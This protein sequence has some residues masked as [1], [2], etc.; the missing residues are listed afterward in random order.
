ME[1]AQHILEK[2]HALT[3]QAKG[4]IADSKWDAAERVLTEAIAL[5]EQNAFAIDLLAKCYAGAGKAELA[6]RTHARAK[7]TREEAWKRQVE[8]DIRSHHELMGKKVQHEIP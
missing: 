1:T 5:D 6:E 2:V 8:G 7:Q 3:E 4:F